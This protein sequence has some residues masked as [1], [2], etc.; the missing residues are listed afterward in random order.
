MGRCGH[1][2]VD[3]VAPMVYR[4]DDPAAIEMLASAD[5][6]RYRSQLVAA[7]DDKRLVVWGGREADGC[8]PAREGE[9][10]RVVQPGE[11]C[12]RKDGARID[13]SS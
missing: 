7:W 11:R 4:P 2:G 3:S 9:A 5:Q 10:T 6:L 13:V 8:G 1:A 12:P